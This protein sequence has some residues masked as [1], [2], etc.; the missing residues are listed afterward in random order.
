MGLKAQ[1]E[2]R[3]RRERD[4][5]RRR[6]ERDANTPDEIQADATHKTCHEPK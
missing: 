2:K 1:K 3:E 4:R 6:K 5:E